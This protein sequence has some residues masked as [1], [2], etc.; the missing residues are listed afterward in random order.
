MAASPSGSESSGRL[1][2]PTEN[3]AHSHHH[4]SRLA[5]SSPSNGPL[6][7]RVGN[8]G[9]TNNSSNAANNN[10]IGDPSNP[11]G[12]RKEYNNPHDKYEMYEKIAHENN[13]I[14]LGGMR[15]G[16]HNQQSM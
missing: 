12:A 11:N 13:N 8:N 7:A 15:D 1:S 14:P 4:R 16:H 2:S 10:N 5:L 9:S 6:D 3:A